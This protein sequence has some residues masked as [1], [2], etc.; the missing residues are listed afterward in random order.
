M[1]TNH[2]YPALAQ[3]GNPALNVSY[4]F[5]KVL[6][7]FNP[8]KY[9]F[10]KELRWHEAFKIWWSSGTTYNTG[11]SRTA[12][13]IFWAFQLK[14]VVPFNTGKSTLIHNDFKKVV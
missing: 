5:Y 2:T 7:L 9:Y 14:I 10:N 8:V 11:L 3:Y 4:G 12:F 13:F 1:D 6:R